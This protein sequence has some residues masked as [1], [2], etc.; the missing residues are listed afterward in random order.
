MSDSLSL[1][2]LIKSSSR[3]LKDQVIWNGPNMEW[4]MLG[5]ME[6]M[7]IQHEISLPLLIYLFIFIFL[8]VALPQILQTGTD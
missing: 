4:K 3:K 6:F 7:K 5:Q 1:V 2:G 8:W